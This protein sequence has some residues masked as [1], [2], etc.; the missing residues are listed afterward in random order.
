MLLVAYVALL[1]TLMSSLTLAKIDEFLRITF[2]QKSVGSLDL[3]QI[4]RGNGGSN[5][6]WQLLFYKVCSKAKVWS[7][8]K[9]QTW[10]DYSQMS[11]VIRLPFLIISIMS[12]CRN[13]EF[14]SFEV[15]SLSFFWVFYSNFEEFCKFFSRAG[16]LGIILSFRMQ[17]WRF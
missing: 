12:A 4:S 16:R 2:M 14:V 13:L 7:L 17:I 5:Q 8:H 9:Y 3:I 11:R 10:L 6:F 1:R 15:F